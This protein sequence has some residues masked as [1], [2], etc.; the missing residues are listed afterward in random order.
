MGQKYDD[1]DLETDQPKRSNDESDIDQ[2]NENER[3]TNAQTDNVTKPFLE[4]RAVN[5][6]SW[7]VYGVYFKSVFGFLSPCLI[8][9]L[10]AS[11]QVLSMIG[12]YWPLFW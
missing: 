1:D 3:L 4:K 6:L 2:N 7:R 5:S 11:C 9:V 10:A 12:D 8:V